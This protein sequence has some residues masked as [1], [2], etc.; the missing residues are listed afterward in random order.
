MAHE[1]TEQVERMTP[2]QANEIEWRELDVCALDPDSVWETV[3]S[4]QGA[5]SLSKETLSCEISL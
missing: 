5:Q 1:P 2:Q 4:I 3:A